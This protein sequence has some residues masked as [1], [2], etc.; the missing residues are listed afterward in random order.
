[1][2]KVW[3]VLVTVFLVISISSQLWKAYHPDPP[4]P[5]LDPR[6]QEIMELNRQM[7]ELKRSGV[8]KDK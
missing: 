8:L 5:R 1:M 3:A 4:D 2:R 6:Y 7:E